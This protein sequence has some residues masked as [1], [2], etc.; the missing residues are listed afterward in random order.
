MLGLPIQILS[1]SLY[2]GLGKL[3]DCFVDISTVIVARFSVSAK[4]QTLETLALSYG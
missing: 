2:I 1:N 3:K 4:V